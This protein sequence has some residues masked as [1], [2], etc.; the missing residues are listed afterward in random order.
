MVDSGITKN[1]YVIFRDQERDNRASVSFAEITG[2]SKWN[3]ETKDLTSFSLGSWE[4]SYD[5][6][7][8][9]S[10]NELHL[11]IQK[12]G[13]GDGESLEMMSPQMVQVLVWKP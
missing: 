11:F 12:V 3:W 9:K 10:S 13:Q 1:I 2:S 4:P 7:R 6:A 5:I 8:W